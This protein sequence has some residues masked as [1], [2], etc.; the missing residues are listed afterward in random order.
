MPVS[1]TV[2]VAG[3]LDCAPGEPPGLSPND[4][5]AR[6]NSTPQDKQ[7]RTQKPKQEAVRFIIDSR[8]S[9]PSGRLNCQVTDLLIFLVSAPDFNALTE[10]GPEYMQSGL[11]H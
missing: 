7:T 1:I 10:F 11:S 5:T 6:A 4:E 3:P 8:G 2:A 9:S